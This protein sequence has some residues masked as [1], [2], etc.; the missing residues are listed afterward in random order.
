MRKVLT[1]LVVFLS[2]VTLQIETKKTFANND[3]LA[4]IY[5]LKLTD[6][7][8]KAFDFQTLKGNYFVISFGATW[9]TTCQA[10]LPALEDI[11]NEFK[12]KPVKFFWV[13]L[14][15]KSVS[16]NELKTFAR[17]LNF[18][19]PILR[20]PKSEAYLKYTNR[21]RL[22]TILFVKDDGTIIAPLIFGMFPT[23]AEYKTHMRKRLNAMLQAETKPVKS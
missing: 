16:N 10:E 5:S 14:D 15:E 6:I 19:Y 8:D 13:S 11:K 2:L 21:Y 18:T 4:N 22:P 9:C 7:N 20:D 3:T 12:D 1:L 17:Q 23:A